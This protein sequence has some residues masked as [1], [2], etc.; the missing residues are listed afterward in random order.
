MISRLLNEVEGHVGFRIRS[1]GDCLR[2]SDIILESNDEDISYNT[3]RRLYGL[4]GSVQ[5][6]TGT[7][8]VLSRLLGYRNYSDF[9]LSSPINARWHEKEAVLLM[10]SHGQ[11]EGSMRRIEEIEN[12]SLRLDVALQLAREWAIGGEYRRVVEL[13]ELPRIN[14][15]FRARADRAGCVRLYC[16]QHEGLFI[17]NRRSDAAVALLEGVPHSLLLEREDGGLAVLVSAGCRP[18]RVAM[19]EARRDALASRSSPRWL[20]CDGPFNATPWLVTP[21]PPRRGEQP[22]RPRSSGPV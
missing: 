18:K 15:T 10:V 22:E 3:L 6:R 7:L 14:L 16:E 19:A 17:S 11:I 1:K 20:V 4:A 2:L 5:P 12:D 21:T 13:L 9:T 8:D